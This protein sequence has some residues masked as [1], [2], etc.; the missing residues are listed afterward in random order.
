MRHKYFIYINKLCVLDTYKI[1]FFPM[2][3]TSNYELRVLYCPFQ[4]ASTQQ[5]VTFTFN[6]IEDVLAGISTLNF[7]TLEHYQTNYPELF[8]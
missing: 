4:I 2:R 1:E 7:N 8:I 5:V 6:S 3:F